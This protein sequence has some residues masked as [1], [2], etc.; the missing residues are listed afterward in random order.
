MHV[1][2]Q[3]PNGVFNW[4]DLSTTD[5]DGAKAFYGGLFGWSFDDRPTDVGSVYSMAQLH[6]HNVAGMGPLPPDQQA[7]GVPAYWSSYVKHDDA[8]GV[9]AR[10]AEAGGTLLMPPM[11]VMQEGRMLI[12]MDPTGAMFGVWQPRNHIGAELVN[13]ADTLVWNELQTRDAGAALSFYGHVFGWTHR[14]DASGYYVLAADGRQ[15]AGM[16]QMDESWG[17]VP[18]N[19]AVYFLAESIEKTVARAQ[20]LGGVIM[21]PPTPAGEMG[22]FAVIQDPQGAVFTAMEFN[23]GFVDP[24]PGA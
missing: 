3:Y 2:T 4:V 8:D 15:Q 12:A 9:A 7:Q 21:V 1:V 6:G 17:D 20:Q 11:D 23:E 24:P 10:V 22:R 16:M 18:P 14:Q 13:M 5:V 19:W